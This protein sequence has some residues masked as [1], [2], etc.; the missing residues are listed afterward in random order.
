MKILRTSRK[1]KWFKLDFGIFLFD[2][3]HINMYLKIKKKLAFK[4]RKNNYNYMWKKMHNS[5]N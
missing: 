1:I 3:K 2:N 4:S 5:S